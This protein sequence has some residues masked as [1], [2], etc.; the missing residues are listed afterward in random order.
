MVTSYSEKS[1]PVPGKEPAQWHSEFVSALALVGPDHS[2]ESPY[3]IEQLEVE[4]IY[5]LYARS[6]AAVLIPLAISTLVLMLLLW[7]VVSHSLLITWAGF[8]EAIALVRWALVRRYHL[9]ARMPEE[10]TYWRILLFVSVAVT[11]FG[12]GM[13][14]FFLAPANSFLH[15]MLLVTFLGGV[16]IVAVANLAAIRP[17]F[18]LFYFSLMAPTVLRLLLSAESSVTIVG[19][20]CIGFSGC[21]VLIVNYLHASITESL[22]LRFTNLD[23]VHSLS[24]AKEQ[25]ERFSTQLS[26]SHAALSKSEAR[27]RSLIEHASDVITILNPDGRVRYIS[28]SVQRWLGYEPE[29]LERKPLVM[30]LHPDDEEKGKEVLATLLCEPESM[31]AFELR[32]Q[33]KSGSWQ[34]FDTVA[35]NLLDDSAVGGIFLSSRDITERKEVEQLKDELVSTVSHELRTPLTSLRGFAEL[36]LNRNFT[37]NEQREFLTIIHSEALRLSNLIDD[38][39]DIQRI[40]SGCQTYHFADAQLFPLLQDALTL[41]SHAEGKHSFVLDFPPTLPV[42]SVDAD[43]IRQI[44]SNLLSNAVK[45]SPHGGTVTVRARHKGECVVIAIIDEGIGIPADAI[46]HLFQKFF[47]V[48][49]TETRRIGGT[50]LGL[51]LVKQIVEAHKGQVWVESTQGKGSIFFFSLPVAI[52]EPAKVVVLRQGKDLR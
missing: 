23:L 31:R 37:P 43:R 18:F 2:A 40:E 27:F 48:D 19:L 12:W 34:V 35:Q 22:R 9:V 3:E 6:A 16:S 24:A 46:P 21:L 49:N 7:P 44:L 26:A 52:L 8:M 30:L 38:F 1:S 5:L 50:G 39:L 13:A 41:F 11:G 36:M 32:W 4:K 28:P 25:A 15:T 45:F 10:I 47:R 20:L 51:A 33:H 29:Q 17:L 14:G 42:V